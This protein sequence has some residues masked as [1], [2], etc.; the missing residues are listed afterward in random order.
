MKYVQF[1]RRNIFPNLIKYFQFLCLFLFVSFTSCSESKNKSDQW[2]SLFNGKDLTGW[3]I[4]FSGNELN[5]NYKNTFQVKDGILKASYENYENFDNKFGHIFYDKIF[6]NYIIRVEY[7]FVGEQVPGG[8]DWAYRNNG[9]MLHCQSPKSMAID[10]DFPVS[11]EAQMLGGNGI[12]ERPTGSVCTPG[13]HIV[14]DSSLVTDHCISSSSKTFH[15][16]QWVT[17]EVEVHGNS[18]I[19]HTVNGEVVME[20][21]KPQLDDTDP[22][23]QKLISQGSNLMLSEGYIAFQAESH[24]TEFRKIEIL[25]LDAK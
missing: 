16:D 22:D 5:Y 14:I 1:T 18:K 12:D 23:A 25:E 6:S 2:I 7:R 15:G 10:Q 13:T 24:P 8:P 20:Y 9:I 3:E 19:K 21:E 17:M 11:I 4:K